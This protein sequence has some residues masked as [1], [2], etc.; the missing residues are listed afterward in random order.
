MGQAQG[1]IKT[2]GDGQREKTMT[3]H[4]AVLQPLQK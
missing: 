2:N 4:C 1:L 3:G